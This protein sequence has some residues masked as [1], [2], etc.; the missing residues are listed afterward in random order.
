MICDLYHSYLTALKKLWKNH[1]AAYPRIK[2]TTAEHE[3][4]KIYADAIKAAV[5]HAI[6]RLSFKNTRSYD[7]QQITDRHLYGVVQKKILLL[8]ENVLEHE[9]NMAQIEDFCNYIEFIAGVRWNK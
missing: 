8:T 7:I 5:F 4:R 1:E 6:F 9:S 2:Y 3:F